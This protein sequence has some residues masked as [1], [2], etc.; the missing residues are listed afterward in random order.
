MEINVKIVN[1]RESHGL[2]QEMFA[3]KLGVSRQA[4]QKWESG[5]GYPLLKWMMKLPRYLLFSS[6]IL[7][8]VRAET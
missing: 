6:M 3:E 8:I 4:V 1:L 7:M 2:T 5:K